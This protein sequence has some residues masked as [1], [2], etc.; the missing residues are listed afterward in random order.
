M[1]DKRS[2]QTR[3]GWERGSVRAT[4]VLRG[5]ALELMAPGKRRQRQRRL[6]C[7]DTMEPGLRASNCGSTLSKTCATKSS[8]SSCILFIPAAD[9]AFSRGSANAELWPQYKLTH[10]E[11]IVPKAPENTAGGGGGDG[12]SKRVKTQ[13]RAPAR[14]R[15][16][17][18]R[19]QEG[20]NNLSTLQG[21]VNI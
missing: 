12:T 5:A 9:A 18:G 14:S 20:L 7:A 13:F 21:A 1:W 4:K 8:T 15:L 2:R 11:R 17:H 16:G 3:L 6:P 19:A 10:S